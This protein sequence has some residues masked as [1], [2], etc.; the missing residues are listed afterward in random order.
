MDDNELII[1]SKAMAVEMKI[2]SRNELRERDGGL[3]SVLYRRKLLDS[4]GFEKTCRE[5]FSKSDEELVE[6]ARAFINGNRIVS[7]TELIAKDAGLYAVLCRRG[8]LGRIGL[9]SKRHEKN[10]AAINDEL[11]IKY[12]KEFLKENEVS[13][14]KEL[15]KVNPG[16]YNVLA[17][18]KLLMALGLIKKR[19]N[20]SSMTDGD[21]ERIGTDFVKKN[22]I[23]AM[24]DLARL[25]GGL[26]KALKKRD[27]LDRVCPKKR[28]RREYGERE[29]TALITRYKELIKEGLPN[30]A[31][32]RKLSLETGRTIDSVCG[33]LCL[34]VRQGA[35]ASNP[36]VQ[37]KG[38]LCDE[39]LLSGLA[40]APEAMERFGEGK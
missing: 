3:Y 15:R 40:R 17:K 26:F 27:L 1:F 4:M 9:E 28:F 37:K 16:L 35:I 6:Q 7:R 23:T 22:S 38:P 39:I 13:T 10:W 30:H 24:K 29:V 20:W 33:K 25:N 34:L 5:W 36:N 32:A 12:A 11:L 14:G 21:L 18:R 2:Y 31:M 19:M 8:L